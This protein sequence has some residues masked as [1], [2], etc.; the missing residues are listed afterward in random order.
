MKL[1]QSIQRAFEIIDCFNEENKELRLNDISKMLDLNINTTRGIVNTLVYYSYLNHD[2]E[3]NMYK[4][5]YVFLPKFKLL[6]N[7]DNNV[8]IENLEEFLKDIAN[9]YGVNTRFHHIVDN[10]ITKIFSEEPDSSRYFLYI[11]DS[12]ELPLNATSS[13]KLILKYSNPEFL[14]MYLKNIPKEKLSP[15]TIIEKD[16]LVEELEKI[17]RSGYSVEIDEVAV[18]ISSV[19]VPIIK[20]GQLVS[21][22][23]ATGTTEI[24]RS[25]SHNIANEIIKFIKSSYL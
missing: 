13:G 10:N 14:Q 5:G 23:S 17:E 19:A 16:S 9:K 8:F 11:K 25:N 15:N 22:I 20:S 1:I 4:L 21:T 24:I 7:R 12:K 3:K 2:E 6:K 18:G